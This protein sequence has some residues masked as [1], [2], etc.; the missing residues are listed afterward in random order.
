M[1]DRVHCEME[2]HPHDTGGGQHCRSVSNIGSTDRDQ[3]VCIRRKS[4]KMR[5]KKNVSV[6]PANVSQRPTTL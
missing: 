6:H 2:G 5:R 1:L 4:P 3:Y